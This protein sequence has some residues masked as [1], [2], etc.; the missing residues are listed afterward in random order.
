MT[1]KK[2]NLIDY[3]P[4]KHLNEPTLFYGLYNMSDFKY[5]NQS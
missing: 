3:D 2:Y 4:V 1:K 5:F